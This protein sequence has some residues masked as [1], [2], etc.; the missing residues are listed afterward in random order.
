MQI[1]K[2]QTCYSDM[3]DNMSIHALVVALA[4]TVKDIAELS[5]KQSLECH[6]VI[7]GSPDCVSRQMFGIDQT[8]ALEYLGNALVDEALKQGYCKN[9]VLNNIAYFYD[10]KAALMKRQVQN[11]KKQ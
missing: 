8:K 3:L 2:H 1:I 10:Q 11:D 5:P 9:V 7:A 6:I 4:N